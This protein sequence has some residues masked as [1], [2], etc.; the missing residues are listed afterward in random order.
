MSEFDDLRNNI[1]R[2]VEKLYPG[3]GNTPGYRGPRYGEWTPGALGHDSTAGPLPPLR[4]P[5]VKDDMSFRTQLVLADGV[6]EKVY[7]V[8]A[9]RARAE[10]AIVSSILPGDV[11]ETFEVPRRM[12]VKQ[13]CVGLPEEKICVP[14]KLGT[15]LTHL[16]LAPRRRG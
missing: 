6:E 7:W 10:Q 8:D 11:I 15:L 13:V 4:I 5:L 16:P 2:E 12:I 14:H 1:E 9:P 3:S